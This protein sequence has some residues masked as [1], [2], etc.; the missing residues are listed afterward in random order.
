MKAQMIQKTALICA[1]LFAGAATGHASPKRPRVNQIKP[2][3]SGFK[4][5]FL[6]SMAIGL[7]A[8]GYAPTAFAG[9][10]SL[11]VNDAGGTT[12]FTGSTNWTIAGAPSA[13][14]DYYVA[15]YFMRTPVDTNATYT[16]GGNS[17][18]LQQPTSTQ[19]GAPFRSMLIK[20]IGDVFIINNFTNATGAV[21]NEGSG[22][23][24]NTFGGN[25]WTIAGNSTLAADQAGPLIVNLPLAGSAIFTNTASTAATTIT[26]NGTNSAFTGTLLVA[27]GTVVF[28]SVSN[29][30]GNPASVTPGQYTLGSGTT[31]KDNV[32]VTLNAANSGVTL[33]GAATINAATA[34]LN[35]VV[36]VPIAGAFGLTK[37]GAGT[38]TLSGANTFSGLNATAG[39]LNINSATALGAIAGTFNINGVS[40]I[41]NTSG[42]AISNANNNPITLGSSFTFAGSTNLNLGTGSVNNG[43][44]GKT[45]TVSAGTLTLGGA[46]TGAGQ[47]AKVGNG[48]L[49]LNGSGISGGLVVSAGTLSGSGTIVGNSSISGGLL[50]PRPSGG[51]ATT[52]TF[53][54]NLTLSSA[55]ANFTLSSSGIGS[56]DKVNYGNSSTLTLD[57]SDTIS[58]TNSGGLDTA[59]VYTLFASGGGT[60]SMGSTPTLIINGTTSDQ[61]TPGNYQ[62]A[63]VGSSLVMQYIPLSTPPT[64]NS[65]T[66]SPSS[67]T[68]NQTTLITVN[69][70]PAAGKTISS[71]SVVA[72]GL[73]GV[74]DPITLTSIGGGDWTGTFTVPANLAPSTYA[75]GGT[76]LQSD[77]ITAPWT[78]NVTVI[79]ANPVWSGNAADNNWNSGANWNS[80]TGPAPGI[81]GDAVTFDGFT[82]LNPNLETNYSVTGVTFNSTAGGFTIGSTGG[83][84]LALTSGSGIVNNSAYAQTLNVPITMSAAQTLDAEAGPLTFSQ[85]ITNRGNLLTVTGPTNTTISGQVSGSGGLTMAGSGVL[86][87]TGNN[88]F[89]GNVF[90]NS[91]GTIVINTGGVVNNGGN[92]SSIGQNGSDNATLTLMG[93]GAFTNSADFNLGDL[94]SAVGTV[95]IQDSAVLSVGELFIGSANAAGSTASGTLNM[96]G[97]TLIEK[98]A[99][100]GQFVIGGRNSATTGGVGVINL[101]NGYI[102]VTCGVRVGDYGTGTVNQFGGLLETTN[103]STGINLRRETTGLGGTYNLNGGI[104]RTEKVTSS[105]TTGTRVFY[106]NGGT[107]QAGSGNLGSVPFLNNLSGAFIRDGGAVI[108]DRGYNITISQALEHSDIGGDNGTDGGLTKLGSGTLTL[109][110]ACSY[111]GNTV[112]SNGT[113]FIAGALGAGTVTVA[114]GTLA[115]NSTIGGAVTVKAG[116]GL[117]PK[118]M[119]GTL[120]VNGNL[121][122][123]AGSTN[124]FAVNGSTPANDSVTAGG[125][126]TY[127]GV[128]NIT[129]NGTF[130]TGQ[131]FTLFSG[132][133]A[134]NASQFASILGSPGNGLGFSFTNGLLSVVSTGP[135][136]SNRLTNSVTG[137]GTTLSLSWGSGWKLQAQ[138]NSLSVGLGTNWV[139]ITDGTLT[140]TNI[141]IDAAKAAVFYRLVYP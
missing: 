93:T 119:G 86:T 44:L 95:N 55:S 50:T 67:V 81:V 80:G 127:G 57:N 17:L 48:T 82:R 41:D 137:G 128:L 1:S 14:N 94:G 31:L 51:G 97:G 64:V 112:V 53:S 15:T 16:F 110:N 65:A 72:D 109:S 8:L 40:T 92:Y 20:S 136:G 47:L 134:T 52:L 71:V 56:N 90:A 69:V 27:G 19:G 75:I 6:L 11:K 139:Y 12:S 66:A 38:L 116:A 73:G 108:D 121:T 96:N 5:S 46:F 32:G 140:S 49:V 22:A 111:T 35:T 114:G 60:V 129:T 113:L 77:S 131:V 104:L 61:V 58:I 62:L 36:A 18:T 105:Q 88:P 87:L 30:L 78:V 28:N 76:V 126:V 4:V 39:Q 3:C 102:S 101:T 91:A 79:A 124:T 25:R 10:A 26:Y 29:V 23:V 85:N 115:G 21:V 106:F 141:P 63:V 43:S 107:L 70:T 98:N 133:G 7:F 2:D 33:T 84:A 120:T 59:N 125:A 99:A 54:G 83:Y 123:S 103:A 42:G 117:A 34:G 68:H 135:S 9:N 74:G 130:T 118:N 13:A 24:T 122:L 138:T 89:T 132:A 37:S 100:V 45:I